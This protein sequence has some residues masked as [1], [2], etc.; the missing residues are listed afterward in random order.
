MATGALS[1]MLKP[2]VSLQAVWDYMLPER[3]SSENKHS[4][5]CVKSKFLLDPKESL[6]QDRPQG[7]KEFFH[8]RGL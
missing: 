2:Q 7:S 5:R 3:V 4:K 6:V 1:E 8:A